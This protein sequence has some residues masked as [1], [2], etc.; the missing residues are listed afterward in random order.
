MK[1]KTTAAVLAFFVGSLGIH[2]FYLGQGLLGLLYFLFCWTFIPAFVALIDFIVFLTMS[3][4]KFN[5]KYNPVQY[6]KMT[7]GQGH[8]IVINNANSGANTPQNPTYQTPAPRKEYNQSVQHQRSSEK[9]NPFYISGNKKYED[10]DFDG[11]IQDY[12]KALNVSPQDHRVHFKLACL[13]SIMENVDSAY[14]HLSKAVENGFYDFDEIKQ[15]DHLAHL[16]TQADFNSFA[17]NGY[18]LS[19]RRISVEEAA[20]DTLELSN[21]VFSRIERLAKLKD[22]GVITEEEFTAQKSKLLN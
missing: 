16:R 12:R 15:N 4:D 17:R 19:N 14:L 2:R 1:S 13:Y 7:A 22:D 3:E 11:A 10:Y 9:E 8:T 6:A 20:G 21:D 5:M 18:V